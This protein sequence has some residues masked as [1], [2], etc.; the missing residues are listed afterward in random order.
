MDEAERMFKI[1]ADVPEDICAA[2]TSA[3]NPHTGFTSIHRT[4]SSAEELSQLLDAAGYAR[5]AALIPE[6]WTFRGAEVDYECAPGGKYELVSKDTVNGMELEQYRLDEQYRVICG[7][8]VDLE[9]DG[10]QASYSSGVTYMT[11]VD[12]GYP[13]QEGLEAKAL[14]V[15]GMEDALLTRYGTSVFMMMYRALE[16]PVSLLA[17]PYAEEPDECAWE[18]L[19]SEGLEPEEFLPLF[20]AGK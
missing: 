3:E 9:K 15:P 1:L 13:D 16:K 4:V 2:I 17:G 11:N 6:G 14:T 18:S 7:Y 5:P 8:R 20:T 12:L 19:G 10:R